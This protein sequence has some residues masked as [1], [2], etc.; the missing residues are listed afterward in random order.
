MCTYL[1]SRKPTEVEWK[2]TEEG[3]RV[4]VSLRTGRIIPK[5]VLERRDGIVPSQWKGE[6]VYECFDW[7]GILFSNQFIPRLAQSALKTG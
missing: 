3:E 1:S 5:P 4:R 6:S 2:F 7:R